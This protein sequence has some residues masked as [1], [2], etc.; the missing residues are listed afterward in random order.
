MSEFEYP[1]STPVSGHQRQD[2]CG[3]ILGGLH[4][5]YRRPT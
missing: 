2:H 1:T 4:H 5:V 3:N